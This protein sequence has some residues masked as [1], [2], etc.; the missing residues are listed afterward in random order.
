LPTVSFFPPSLSKKIV[1]FMQNF[2]FYPKM[3]I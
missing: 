3:A 2:P 1:Y